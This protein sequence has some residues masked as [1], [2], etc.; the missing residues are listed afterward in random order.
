MPAEERI[1]RDTHAHHAASVDLRARVPP[2]R[3]HHTP[4]HRVATRTRTRTRTGTRTSAG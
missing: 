1:I 2:L 3:G 4:W